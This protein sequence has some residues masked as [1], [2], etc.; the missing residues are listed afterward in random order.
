MTITI[1]VTI[2]GAVDFYGRSG[3]RSGSEVHGS[4]SKVEGLAF[5]LRSSGL[6]SLGLMSEVFW[7]WV[8]GR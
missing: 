3:R 5:C 7:S 4:G 1:I 8:S 6:R 2:I